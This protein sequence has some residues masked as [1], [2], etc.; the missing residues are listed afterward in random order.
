MS[1]PK[2]GDKRPYTPKPKFGKRVTEQEESELKKPLHN[3]MHH[4]ARHEASERKYIRQ[5]QSQRSL[6]TESLLLQTNLPAAFTVSSGISLASAP[7]TAWSRKTFASDGASSAP[8][9]LHSIVLVALLRSSS[10][11]VVGFPEATL[12]C[13][14]SLR[15]SVT[16]TIYV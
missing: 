13:L 10:L 2:K 8:L 7:K 3:I 6:E 5:K 4:T 15:T 11:V 12:F 14:H 16:G 1:Q 9:P